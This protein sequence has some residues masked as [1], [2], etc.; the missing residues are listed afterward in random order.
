ME[1]FMS[2]PRNGFITGLSTM[3]GSMGMG[4]IVETTQAIQ[5]IAIAFGGLAGA[6][7]SLVSLFYLIKNKGKK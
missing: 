3:L 5:H 1:H 7:L 6:A 2:N 4:S